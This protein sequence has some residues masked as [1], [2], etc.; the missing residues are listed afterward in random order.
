MAATTVLY[1]QL[2]TSLMN[3]RKIAINKRVHLVNVALKIA[4]NIAH[5]GSTTAARRAY[6]SYYATLQ[7]VKPV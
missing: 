2:T 6:V 1:V 3:L 7:I 4:L 5:L